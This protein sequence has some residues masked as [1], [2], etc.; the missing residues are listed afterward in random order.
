MKRQNLGN[1][2]R[3]L[4]ALGVDCRKIHNIHFI[5]AAI[6]EIIIEKDYKET[7]QKVCRSYGFSI[8]ER[9]DPATSRAAQV[10]ESA[11]QEIRK[12]FKQR[13]ATL[14]KYRVKLTKPAT[15]SQ[16]EK[17]PVV[18]FVNSKLKEANI[19]INAGILFAA[20]SN[21]AGKQ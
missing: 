13:M 15:L 21:A 11:K 4:S 1:A 9:Y 10:S 8:L 14:L 5:G 6:A 7:L 20:A 2:R 19:P 18:K 16:F 3:Q 12:N 17:D